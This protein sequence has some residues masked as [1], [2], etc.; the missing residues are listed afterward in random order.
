MRLW[1]VHPKYLDAK[2]LTAVWREGLLARKVLLGETRGYRSHP[3][4]ERFRETASPVG[5]VDT[6]LFSICAEALSRSYRFDRTKIGPPS[7]EATL[8]VTSGQLTYEMEH[9]RKKLTNRDPSWFDSLCLIAIPEAHPLFEVQTGDIE[10]WERQIV[11]PR[12][13]EAPGQEW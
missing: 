12:E 11:S 10:P 7:A 2:G 13:N 6:Y 8:R 3:Q 1:S 4:L 9:L 5:F